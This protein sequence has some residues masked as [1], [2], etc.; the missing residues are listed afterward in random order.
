MLASNLSEDGR[1]ERLRFGDVAV[2]LDREAVSDVSSDNE[3]D[4]LQRFAV[5]VEQHDI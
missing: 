3:D 5:L 1:E 4:E 2:Q